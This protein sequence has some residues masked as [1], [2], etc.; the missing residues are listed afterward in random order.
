MF[1]F[2][3]YK[4]EEESLNVSIGTYRRQRPT[5]NPRSLSELVGSISIWKELHVQ[6]SLILKAGAMRLQEKVI[7]VKA[8][9][10]VQFD[11]GNNIVNCYMDY[12]LQIIILQ[13]N[14]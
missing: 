6:F 14:T 5:G 2:Q 3:I 10:Q 11:K 8:N 9:I 7:E 1:F 4:N 13:V 12:L